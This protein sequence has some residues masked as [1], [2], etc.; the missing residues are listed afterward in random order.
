V[1]LSARCSIGN[2]SIVG[3][4][5]GIHT[6]GGYHKID[7]RLIKHL[8]TKTDFRA[9]AF[10]SNRSTVEKLNEY[11]TTRSIDAQAAMSGIYGQFQS[12]EVFELIKWIRKFNLNNRLQDF[13]V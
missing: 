9:I 3:L 8:I 5:G 12:N 13:A 10:E 2:A 6:S 7:V 4:G 1:T 11:V